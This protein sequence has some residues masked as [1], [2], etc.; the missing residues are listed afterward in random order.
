[1]LLV[2]RKDERS[3]RNLEYPE[4]WLKPSPFGNPLV[5]VVFVLGVVIVALTKVSKLSLL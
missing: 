4:S 2:L 1:M 3:L 5:D